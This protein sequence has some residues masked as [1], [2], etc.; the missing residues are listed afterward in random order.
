MT[1][2]AAIRDDYMTSTLTYD[3]IVQKYGVSL[4]QVKTHG[5]QEGWVALREEFRTKC[6]PAVMDAAA[7]AKGRIAKNIYAAAEKALG[8][9]TAALDSAVTGKELRALT[10]AIKD[11]KEIMDIRPDLDVQ[12]QQARIEK[13][14]RDAREEDVVT[15]IDVQMEGDLSE[16]V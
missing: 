11:I 4:S 9:V 8:K 3:E 7:A 16:Y 1:D 13:L 15:E 14:R 12:E 5:G 6:I 2:W 10:A